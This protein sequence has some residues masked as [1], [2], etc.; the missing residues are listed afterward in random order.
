MAAVRDVDI[1]TYDGLTLKGTLYSVGPKKPCIIMSHGFS[2]H[3]EHFLPELAAKFNEAGYGALVYDNRCWGDSEGHPRCEVDPVKQ[4]RDYFDAFN[5]AAVLPEV[6]P[7][8]IV[9]WGSSMSGGNAICA[10]SMNKNLAGI[11]SQVPFVSGGAMARITGAPKSLLVSHRAAESEIHMPIYPN[12]V[13]EV[14]DGTTKAILKDAGAVKFAEEMARRGYN[15]DKTATLQSMTNTIMHEP[16]GVIHHIAPTPLLMVVADDDVCTY[17]HLQLEAFEKALQPKTLKIVKGTGHFDLYYECQLSK[18]PSVWTQKASE[19]RASRNATKTPDTRSSDLTSNVTEQ[20]GLDSQLPLPQ[21]ASPSFSLQ[22]MGAGEPWQNWQMDSLDFASI[23]EPAAFDTWSSSIPTDQQ[24]RLD[25]IGNIFPHSTGSSSDTGSTK[26]GVVLYSY[27]QFLT[28]GNLH[29]IPY[30]DVTYLESQGCLHVPNTLI[31][32]V[33]MKAYFTY[34]HVFIP[35][36]DE[37]EFWE[38]LSPSTSSSPKTTMS[39]LVLR[40]MLF[41]SSAYVPLPVLRQLGYHDICSARADLYRKAK[42]RPK[43]HLMVK[44]DSA[45]LVFDME[46]ET[47]HLPVAQSALL[48][49]SWVPESP[50]TTSP[51][52]YR[53][54]LSLAIHHAKLINTH[55]HAG[56]CDVGTTSEPRSRTLRRLWWCCIICDRLSSLA[57][58]FRLQITP[59]M[60]D[61]ENCVPLGFADLQSEIHRSNVFS[62]T[63]KRQ[64]ISLFSKSLSLLMLLTEV[65]PVAYPFETR[66]ESSPDFSVQEEEN[67]RKSCDLLEDWYNSAKAEFPPLHKPIAVEESDSASS[68]AVHTNLMYIYYHMSCIA[69]CNRRV[70]TQI[71]GTGSPDFVLQSLQNSN[72]GND[73]RGEIEDSVLGL[74]KCIGSLTESHLAKYLPIT[75]SGCLAIPLALHHINTSLSYEDDL[76]PGRLDGWPLL[77]VNQAQ[78]H[79]QAVTDASDTFSSQYYGS[80]WVRE[81]AEHV[82]KLAKSFNKLSLHSGQE[83]MKDWVDI[84][85][86]HPEAY[87]GL[88]WTVDMCINRRKLPETQDFPLC[89]RNHVERLNESPKKV[90]HEMLNSRSL[91]GQKDTHLTQSLDYLM[92]IQEPMIDVL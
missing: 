60:L 92:G 20:L 17:T 40:A 37:G 56:I 79:L 31:L 49:M 48:L 39:L 29:A 69:L 25:P 14:Q 15:F 34:A 77:S 57:C 4:T 32:D 67:I 8:K 2:G 30:Q 18:A 52:P 54:W 70:F 6:D 74:S 63:T 46:A 75:V 61:M 88:V 87:L 65:I 3:R 23:P 73:I 71:S 58:R 51:V 66:L 55:R 84:L 45:K 43:S 12:S 7:T 68:I 81:V 35:L 59:D 42:V 89:L 38:M 78:K 41:A 9:Y 10:A 28:V 11:I 36:I 19:R 80:H 44:A 26:D 85:V 53:T 16:V 21:L 82:A 13:E 64:L 24:P 27:F 72:K 47:A 5:F 76:V 22:T 62:P 83:A 1:T 86:R 50:T 90:D 91:G 33:F